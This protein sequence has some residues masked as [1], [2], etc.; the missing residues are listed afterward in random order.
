MGNKHIEVIHF[1]MI[2]KSSVKEG[3]MISCRAWPL[4]QHGDT[5]WPIW[6]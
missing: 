6:W 1:C 5:N 4:H 2:L 3:Y